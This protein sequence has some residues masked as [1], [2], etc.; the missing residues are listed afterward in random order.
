MKKIP[1]LLI[2]SAF[3]LHGFF[4]SKVRAESHENSDSPQFIF[5]AAC[6]YGK[7]CWAVNYVDV[8]PAEGSAQ[9]FRC[10]H[11]TYDT[12]K[13]VDF[14]LGSVAH[15]KAGVDV[16]AAA[17][18]KVLRVRDSEDDTL[19]TKDEQ[20]VIQEA[21]KECGNGILIDHGDGLQTIYCHLK[22]GSVVVK[23]KQRV[24]TGQKIGEIG[25]SGLA[26]FPHLHFGVIWEDG[27]V[28]PY[29]GALNT[30]GCNQK[31]EPL[32]HIGLP[33]KYDPVV[34][35]DGGFRASP[36]DFT[37]MHKGEESP[38]TL[39]LSSAAFVF[40]VGFYNVEAGD[41]VILRITDPDGYE[42]VTQRKTVEKIRARQYYFTGRKIG[43]VQ[44]K[45]GVYEGHVTI[46]RQSKNDGAI[47]REKTFSVTVE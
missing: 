45:P 23:P 32:W 44:L 19:K 35:F 30:D 29:T 14:A 26:E 37:A 47:M 42:F 28:D 10:N 25:Q 9:D 18:G 15:M 7:D 12:H 34:I 41:Q 39:S 33:I 17:S 13:G 1:F 43:R 16:L 8:D 3:L 38:E 4:Y 31:K 11:K 46:S 24:K 21:K 36:P 5:P 22:Q 2:V 20:K 40:W 27:V 6:S